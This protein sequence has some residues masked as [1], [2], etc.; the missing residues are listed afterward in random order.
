MRQT[1]ETLRGIATVSHWARESS[2][3]WGVFS[4]AGARVAG[5]A[6]GDSGRCGAL[7][8]TSTTTRQLPCGG[9]TSAL[10]LVSGYWLAAWMI[11]SIFPASSSALRS[12]SGTL[13]GG[14]Q[15]P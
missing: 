11:A 12:S 9:C 14:G 3:S 6:G 8:A 1:G 4:V 10:M 13:L 7:Y 15:P 5:A 2:K